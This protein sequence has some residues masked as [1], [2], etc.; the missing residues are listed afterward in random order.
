M[1]PFSNVEKVKQDLL[2]G[3]QSPDCKKCWDTE[4]SGLQSRRIQENVFLDYK[5][6]RDIEK[7]EQDCINGNAK[8]LMHQIQLSNLCNQ[9]C[10]TCNQTAST[11]WGEIS[12]R[13]NR[14][15]I[16]IFKTDLNAL[17]IDYANVKRI[18]ILGGEPLFD[19]A[20]FDLLELLVDHGNTDCFISFVTNGSVILT[21]KLKR[22]LTKFTDLNI[23][24][25]IDG[26]ESRFEYMRWPGKWA[27]L[28]HNL[29]AYRSVVP[30]ISVSYTVST[31]NAIYYQETVDWFAS[32]A[33]PYQ[34]N[35]VRDPI[36]ASLQNAP[37][38]IKT[39]PGLPDAISSYAIVN[40]REISMQTLAEN[41]QKQDVMKNIFL[42]D[43]MPELFDIIYDNP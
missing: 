28:L 19:P 8:L 33:L 9:A 15:K 37:I 14:A 36:W 25:S 41:L 29:D 35:M 2:Q 30:S 18:N 43:Y 16:P 34:V 39:R 11:K 5:L 12:N 3:I 10:V 26:I 1:Q 23:C 22:L 21:D 17:K 31:V 6:D 27:T 38:E 7:I 4:N 13:D 20:M 32:Q 40:G 42:K 24:I